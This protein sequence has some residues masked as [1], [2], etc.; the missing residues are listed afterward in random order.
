M[1][2]VGSVARKSVDSF[3]RLFHFQ[4]TIINVTTSMNASNPHAIQARP[5]KTPPDRSAAIAKP[6]FGEMFPLLRQSVGQLFRIRVQKIRKHVT[7]RPKFAS[8]VHLALRVTAKVIVQKRC[9][10]IEDHF[11]LIQQSS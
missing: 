1:N 6:R 4:V 9:V 8:T 5:V 11:A 7:M 3:Y 2:L 10:G